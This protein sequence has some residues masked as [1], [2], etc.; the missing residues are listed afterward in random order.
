MAGPGPAFNILLLRKRKNNNFL[1]IQIE[2][3][4]I[5]RWRRD[6]IVLLP[7]QLV[8]IWIIF[9][10]SR[11][12][13]GTAFGIQTHLESSSHPNAFGKLQSL[14]PQLY[15]H[16]TG[17][18]HMQHGWN[19]MPDIVLSDFTTSFSVSKCTPEALWHFNCP[20]LSAYSGSAPILPKLLHSL[21]ATV[22]IL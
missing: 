2:A 12:S 16:R 19:V 4:L 15:I 21:M 1:L 18:N 22:V 11:S 14:L 8:V 6:Y 20:G 13:W 17:A 9:K 7:E 5:R 3:S 10:T